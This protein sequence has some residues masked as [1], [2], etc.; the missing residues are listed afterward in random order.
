MLLEI[1]ILKMPF[2][3]QFMTTELGWTY[4]AEE[5]FLP[6]LKTWFRNI[7]ISSGHWSWSWIRL[8]ADSQSTSTSG[9]RASFWDP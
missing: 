7:T 3:S 9:Y 2:L 4:S 6:D 8:A 5:V 1:T